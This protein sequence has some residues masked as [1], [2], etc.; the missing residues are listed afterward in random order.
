MHGQKNVKLCPTLSQN[1]P[2]LNLLKIRSAGLNMEH[3]DNKGAEE[4][5]LSS[6]HFVHFMVISLKDRGHHNDSFHATIAL[7]HQHT[8]HA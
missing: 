5:F 8:Q 2:I 1:I 7:S 3:A 4:P 6:T